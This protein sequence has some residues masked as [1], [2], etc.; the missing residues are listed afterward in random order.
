MSQNCTFME[1]FYVI[2]VYSHLEKFICYHQCY[3]H[4]FYFYATRLITREGGPSIRKLR[5]ILSLFSQ[6]L[7]NNSSQSW[8][9]NYAILSPN[10][11][12]IFY[13]TPSWELRSGSGT[14]GGSHFL[15]KML[16]EN[17]F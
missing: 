3:L 7:R 13:I 17:N 10:C 11:S 15:V 4:V 16:S 8:C 6:S 9:F 2:G 1:D 5:G 12:L 14:Y